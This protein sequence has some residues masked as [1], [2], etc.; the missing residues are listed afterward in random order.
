[1]TESGAFDVAM[2]AIKKLRRLNLSCI[3]QTRAKLIHPVGKT[4]RPEIINLLTVYA[5]ENE[6]SQ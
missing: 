1:V 2:I 3:D 6:L 4:V 5:N